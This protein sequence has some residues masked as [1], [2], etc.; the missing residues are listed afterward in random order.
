[1]IVGAQHVIIAFNLVVDMM[2]TWPASGRQ[3][4]G[5]MDRVDPHQRDIAD[6]V[7]DA[8]VADLGPE[9]LVSG[10]I[11]RVEADVAEAGYS[12]IP[13]SEVALAAAFR[14]DRQFDLIAGRI[15][16][17]DERLHLA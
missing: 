6:A 1:M 2:N 10:R 5:V 9:F 14:P 11:G 17:A 13:R 16:E 8:R 15:L 12:G 3:S 7:A 4:D